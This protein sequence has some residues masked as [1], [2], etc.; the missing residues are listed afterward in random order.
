MFMCMCVFRYEDVCVCTGYMCVCIGM[1]MCMYRCEDA[2]VCNVCVYHY[3]CVCVYYC[4]WV[5]VT[6]CG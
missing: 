1:G 3:G 2:F 6:V 5:I 4:V